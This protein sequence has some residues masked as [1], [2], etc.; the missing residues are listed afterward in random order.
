[1]VTVAALRPVRSLAE[2]QQLLYRHI[3]KTTKAAFRGA[4]GLER[5]RYFFDLLGNPQ[6]AIPAIH[7]A[8]TSG[9]GSIAYITASLLQA[10][11]HN[12]GLH[13]SPHVYDLRERM[14]INGGLISEAELC[15]H[16][17]AILLVI[18]SMSLTQYG[19]PTYFEVTLALA[20]LAFKHHKVAYVVVET[21]IGGTFDSTNT[22]TRQDKLA[23]LAQ[24][25]IDHSGVLGKTISQISSQKAGIIQPQ[26]HAI[27]LWQSPAARSTFESRALNINAELEY[28]RPQ[29][30][31]NKIR[32]TPN[33]T[34]FDLD[35]GDWNWSTI[36]LSLYGKH[37]AWNTGLA[38]RA[39]QYLGRR[40]EFELIESSARTALS[41]LAIPARFEIKTVK[42]KTIVLDGAHNPQKFRSLLAALKSTFPDRHFTFLIA[43]TDTKDSRQ[44]YVGRKRG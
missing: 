19:S 8:G 42:D 41:K 30:S 38:I 44:D 26:N 17:N 36:L 34:T 7:I 27:A 11:G 1:M 33:G 31:L 39:V 32:S 24:I 3:P 22:I 15:A 10:A 23:V 16:L 37:Q 4:D 28:F 25:G 13:V 21:G 5:S 20:Y 35:L 18:E 9:K 12:V 2:A 6:D 29:Q 43:M 14:M 40:D